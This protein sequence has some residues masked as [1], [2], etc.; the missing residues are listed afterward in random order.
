MKTIKE[1]RDWLLENAVDEDGDLYLIGLDFS[2]FDGNVYICNMKVKNDL[3][4]NFQIVGKSL[5]QNYQKS[6]K[7]L[8]QDFQKVGKNLY[9]D[10]QE[11]GEDFRN[12]KLESNEYWE[13]KD[14]YVVRRKN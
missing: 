14:F 10:S 7:D 9:Q 4:Q 2:D 6:G 5:M 13:E 3:Y 1:I 11:V 8:Y 12:H